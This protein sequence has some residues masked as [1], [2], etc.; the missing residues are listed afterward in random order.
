MWDDEAQSI[1]GT[2]ATQPRRKGKKGQV[3]M[4]KE[5]FGRLPDKREAELFI[6]TNTSGME[7][8]ITNYGAAL[9]RL[10]TPD[11]NGKLGDIVLGYDSLKGYLEDKAYLGVVVGRYGNRIAHAKFELNGITY[12]LNANIGENTLHGGLLGFSKKLWQ[13]REITSPE[14][15]AVE[16]TYSSPDGEEG[17]PG[18]LV[19][20]ITYTLTDN[21]ELRLD[22]TAKTNKETVLNLTNHSYFNLAGQ[23]NGDI[24]RH[25][26]MIHADRFTPTDAGSIPTGELRSVK[27]TPLDFRKSTL[28][29]LRINQDDEQLRFGSGYDQNWVLNQTQEGELMLAA[30]VS[31]PQSGR[32]LEVW[33]T[34]P[35]LQFYTGNFL[36]GTIVGKDGKVYRHRFG[37]CLETQH[38][39]DSPNQPS[40]P[41]TVLK[42][43]Q[44]YKSTTTFRF[45]SAK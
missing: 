12:Q 30:R 26:I 43:G 6:L 37:L 18:N 8:A 14:G 17:Y 32:V 22:Y 42:P 2:L 27:G 11:R 4:R 25:E 44:E 38:F 29:G 1:L 31:E 21:N 16:L 3:K 7:A 5:P 41:S 35:G 36:D 10:S 45:P 39:P 9:V 33:T 13:A 19:A 28:I 15:S 23:G 20:S 34:E 24:L 40:F